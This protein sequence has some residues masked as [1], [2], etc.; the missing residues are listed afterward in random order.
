VRLVSSERFVPS[1]GT[2]AS[3]EVIQCREYIDAARSCLELAVEMY[4]GAEEQVAGAPVPALEEVLIQ[5]EE[6]EAILWDVTVVTS[7][8]VACVV[9]RSKWPSVSRTG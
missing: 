9:D 7:R 1:R 6:A 8:V 3:R 4:G 5:L 2:S